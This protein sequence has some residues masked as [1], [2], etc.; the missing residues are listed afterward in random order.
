[1]ED[2][3]AWIVGDI[4]EPQGE[5]DMGGWTMRAYTKEQQERLN[6]D[7]TGEA[8]PGVGEPKDTNTT[9][10]EQATSEGAM[11]E[12]AMEDTPAWIVGDIEEPQ[13]EKDM[14][15]WTMRAYTKE[16]QERLNVDETGEAKV[17]KAASQ[18]PDLLQELAATAAPQDGQKDISSTTIVFVALVSL[19]GVAVLALGVAHSR[20]RHLSH[21]LSAV[22]GQAMGKVGAEE[23]GT[24]KDQV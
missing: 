14:G 6:V 11:D 10:E 15:G 8:R 2:T 13:G 21:E 20:S 19:M 9:D 23:V 5:K 17:K 18:S 24:S 16:Q 3:P 4:E 22:Y 1:M 7:E 12:D